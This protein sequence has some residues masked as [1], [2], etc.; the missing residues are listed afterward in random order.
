MSAAEDSQGN[1]PPSVIRCTGA[2]TVLS[3][4]GSAHSR[5]EPDGGTGHFVA[6][7]VALGRGTTFQESLETSVTDG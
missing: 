1:M 5:L 7:S 4:F 2:D 3:P 6:S